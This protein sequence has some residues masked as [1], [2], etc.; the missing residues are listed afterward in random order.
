MCI[1]DRFMI[2]TTNTSFLIKVLFMLSANLGVRCGFYQKVGSLFMTRKIFLNCF[3][4]LPVL[5]KYDFTITHKSK[6]SNGNPDSLNFSTQLTNLSS[7]LGKK[8][9]L[10][11]RFFRVMSSQPI[12][13]GSSR[14]F[15]QFFSVSLT[16]FPLF[17]ARQ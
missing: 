17:A 1:R 10:M 2:I 7:S 9:R 11:S 6:V 4:T 3:T 13:Y 12:Y 8:N 5:F 14:D 15:I 16:H